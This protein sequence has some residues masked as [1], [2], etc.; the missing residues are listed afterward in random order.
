MPGKVKQYIIDFLAS[1]EVTAPPPLKRRASAA[2][3]LD[4]GDSSPLPAVLLGLKATKTEKWL[5]LPRCGRGFKRMTN[6]KERMWDVGDNHSVIRQDLRDIP[7]IRPPS[8]PSLDDQRTWNIIALFII[9]IIER[10]H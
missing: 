1:R 4:D 9:G 2:F 5:S 10:F 7:M 8:D 3:V 6:L